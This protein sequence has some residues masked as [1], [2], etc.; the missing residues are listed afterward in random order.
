M[1]GAA[2]VRA[3]LR[4]AGCAATGALL[5]AAALSGCAR[6]D[7]TSLAVP[8]ES[9]PLALDAARAALR[10]SGF[11]IDRVDAA[12]GVIT[13]RPKGTAGIATPWDGEQ[14][15]MYQEWEDFMNRHQRTVRI[16]FSPARQAAPEPA[17]GA[18]ATPPDLTEAAG[19]L[20][21]H[22]TVAV[23]RAYRSNWRIESSAIRQSRRYWDRELA[24]R[25]MTSYEVP[26]AQDERLAARLTAAIERRMKRAAETQ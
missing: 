4:R 10:D 24:S 5:A 19:T 11:T 12:A 25:G 15:T 21:M 13:T 9:Y 8:A 20:T 3:G 22:T 7:A 17:G 14:S 1:R 23:E 6:P 18:G 26:V 16:D 2:R